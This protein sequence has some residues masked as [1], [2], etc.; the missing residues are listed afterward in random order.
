MSEN[1]DRRHSTV[2]WRTEEGTVRLNVGTLE[3]AS[4]FENSSTSGKARLP[5]R[6]ELIGEKLPEKFIGATFSPAF[7]GLSANLLWAWG[8]ALFHP[9]CHRELIK[10]GDRGHAHH[11]SLVRG[12]S[13]DAVGELYW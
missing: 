7:C 3:S 4:A 5:V 10:E 9:S 12:V 6:D 1:A 8:N 11:Q 2:R 13:A